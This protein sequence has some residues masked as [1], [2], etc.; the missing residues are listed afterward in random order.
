[1]DQPYPIYN[2]TYGHKSDVQKHTNTAAAAWLT[3]LQ[4]FTNFEFE[5]KSK[6]F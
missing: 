5:T 6:Q 4:L 1:M 2:L 3:Q